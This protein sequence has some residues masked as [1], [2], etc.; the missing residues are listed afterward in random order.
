MV[1]QLVIS[2]CQT[3]PAVRE[4]VLCHPLIRVLPPLRIDGSDL[5]RPSEVD[6][7]VLIAIIVARAPSALKG[8][9]SGKVQAPQV[10]SVITIPHGRGC[11]RV[12]GDLTISHA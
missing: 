10:W 12:V 3:V 4:S 2:P 5:G 9:P 11:D 6:L 7:K 8:S 1:F